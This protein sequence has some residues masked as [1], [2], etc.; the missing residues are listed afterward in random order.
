M[1]MILVEILKSCIESC[2]KE[3]PPTRYAVPD[4]IALRYELTSGEG[5]ER[6]M[7]VNVRFDREIV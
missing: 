1:E 3:P 7:I 6:G 5:K 2:L 4:D